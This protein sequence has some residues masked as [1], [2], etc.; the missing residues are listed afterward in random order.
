[1]I[2]QTSLSRVNNTELMSEAVDEPSISELSERLKS[3]LK[4]PEKGQGRAKHPSR[5]PHEVELF[6]KASEL[7]RNGHV[8]QGT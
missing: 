8:A 7:E 1:M 6:L 4:A 2:G 3:A 5:A